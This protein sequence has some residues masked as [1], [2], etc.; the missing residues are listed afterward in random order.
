[1]C[2]LQ[3]YHFSFKDTCELK[4]KG[5]KRTSHASGNQKKAECLSLYPTK[6]TVSQN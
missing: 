1:M 3:E 6:Y 2:F 5:Y 4:V